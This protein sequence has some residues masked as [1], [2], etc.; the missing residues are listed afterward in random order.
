MM[1][2]T[3]CSRGDYAP[4]ETSSK[5]H[6]ITRSTNP[7]KWVRAWVDGCRWRP[8]TNERQLVA[9][10]HAE[11][12]SDCRED[13]VRTP[14]RKRHLPESSGRRDGKTFKHFA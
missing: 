13:P 9:V 14:G 4:L 1:K 5:A 6:Y 10:A 11:A 12:A 7:A 8:P 2:G 3:Q